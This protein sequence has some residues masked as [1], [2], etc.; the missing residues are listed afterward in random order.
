MKMRLSILVIG[1]VLYHS[2]AFCG[3]W[4]GVEKLTNEAEEVNAKQ[5]KLDRLDEATQKQAQRAKDKQADAERKQAMKSSM[6]NQICMQYESMNSPT[7]KQAFKN[8]KKMKQRMEKQIELAI[9]QT[10]IEYKRQFG[11]NYDYKKYCKSN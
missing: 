9:Q 6:E 5:E 10:N 3:F 4:G 2:S 7:M 11:K 1:F 8:D